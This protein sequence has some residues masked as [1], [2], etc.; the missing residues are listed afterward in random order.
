M[1]VLGV[2]NNYGSYQSQITLRG[3]SNSGLFAEVY[4]HPEKNQILF[5]IYDTADIPASSSQK[6]VGTTYLPVL[7]IKA[8]IIYEDI[9]DFDLVDNYEFF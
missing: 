8:G 3:N 6:F 4:K 5:G 9:F 1:D 7:P 2:F